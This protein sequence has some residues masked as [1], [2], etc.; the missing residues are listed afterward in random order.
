MSESDARL[1]ARAA[2]GDPAAFD[3]FVERHQ[4]AVLRLLRAMTDNH[5]DVEDAFQEAFVAAW[6]HAGSFAGGDSA[7]GWILQVARHA[8]HRQHR[9]RAGEPA[10]FDDLDALGAAAG[11]GCDEPPDALLARLAD[12]ELLERALDRLAPADREVLVLRDLEEL[13]GE[14]AAAMLGLELPALKSRLHRA[15]LRFG[16]ALRELTDADT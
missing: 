10:R 3:T 13:S 4:A 12:R 6:R 7:R 9:R 16:A 2:G 1:L 15:R 14:E 5:A 11:W 8:L